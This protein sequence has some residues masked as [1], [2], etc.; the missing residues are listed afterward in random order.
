MCYEEQCSNCGKTSWGG[1]G[2]HVRSLYDR[3]PQHQRCLCRQW[4]GI[5]LNTN[6]PP[7]QQQP[8]SSSV[9]TIL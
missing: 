7:Q 4:P 2:R 9:C 3:I 8:S 1:C 5:N 6:S